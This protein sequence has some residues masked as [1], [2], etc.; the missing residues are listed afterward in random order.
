MFIGFGF[1][2]ISFGVRR[3]E[4]EWGKVLEVASLSARRS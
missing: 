3:A 4:N 1:I 2:R